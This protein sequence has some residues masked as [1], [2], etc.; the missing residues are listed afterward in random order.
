MATSIKKKFA[1]L[2]VNAVI[3]TVFTVGAVMMCKAVVG[4]N[5]DNDLCMMSI[6]F[7]VVAA[8]FGVRTIPSLSIFFRRSKEVATSFAERTGKM[9][10]YNPNREKQ[11]QQA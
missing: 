6:G 9:L 10:A 7:L 8:T 1:V 11:G 4:D 2:A 3:I 5:Y